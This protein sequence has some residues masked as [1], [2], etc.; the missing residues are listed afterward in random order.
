MPYSTYLGGDSKTARDDV[1]GVTMDPT[2]LI[3]ATGRTQSK[4]FPMTQGGPTIFNSA[5]YL[6]EGK[7]GDEPYLVKINPA[8]PGP[9]SLVY[10]TFLGGG[11]ASGQWGS[12]CTSIAVDARRASYVA[13]ET[14]AQGAPYVP[15]DLKAPQ[16]FPY[17]PNAFLQAPQ[18]SEDALLMNINPSG[19]NLDYSTYLGGT[20]SDRTYG[21]AVDPDGNVVLTGLTFSSN[22]PAQNWPGNVG[23]Q[24]AFVSKFSPLYNPSN[25]ILDHGATHTVTGNITY[26]N[27]YIGQNSTGALI[28]EGFIN[29]VNNN[30]TLGQN[31]GASGAYALSDGS[32]TVGGNEYIGY[33]GS[34]SFTQTG[35]THA[36]TGILILAADAVSSGAYSLNGGSLTV[37]SYEAVG[38]SGTGSFTQSGG[39]HTV[40]ALYLGSTAG[41]SGS[42]TLSD[43]GS[44]SLLA[45]SGNEYIG[46][47]GAGTFT[48]TGGSHTVRGNLTLATTV[49]SSGAYNFQGG[50]LTA[51]TITVN[52]GGFFNQ[53]GGTL[54]GA[55]TLAGGT[56]SAGTNNGLGNQTM[57]INGGTLQATTGTTPILGNPL[58]VGGNF[59]LGGAAGSALELT[60]NLD[61]IGNLLTHNGASND[62]LS[63]NLS[64][65]ATG[66]ITVTAGTLNLTGN[67]AAYAG[68]S[69]VTGGTLNQQGIGN[70]TGDNVVSGGALNM[71]SAAAI[72]YGIVGGANTITGGT[73]DMSAPLAFYLNNTTVTN[74]T[75]NLSAGTYKGGLTVGLGGIFNYTGGAFDPTGGADITTGVGSTTTI[76]SGLN[77]N[78]G[79]GALTNN[80]TTTVNGALTGDL[81]NNAG[82]TVGGTG[83]ITGALVSNGIVNPGNSPGTLTVG[84]Y[85]PGAANTQVVEIASA[86]DY[87]RIVT[88]A[89]VPGAATLNGTLSP[90]LLGGYLPA[91]NQVFPGIVEGTSAGTV[92]GAFNAIDNPRVGSSRTLFWQARYT[93]TTADL[94]AVG[95][96]TPPD[97]ALSRSQQSVGN[98]LHSIAPSTA[99]GDMLTVL[100]AINALT[101]NAGVAAAYTEI[102][103]AKY[104]TLPAMTFP[105]TRMQFQYLQNRLARVR[106]EAALDREALS[107]GRSG[108]GRG[109]NFSYDSNTRMILAASNLT[110]SDAGARYI[111]TEVEQRWGIYL[112]P[113]ANWGS[114]DA[115]ANLAGYRYKNFGF[116]LG[117]EY[118][119]LDNLLVGL[120]TGYSRTI[121]SAGGSGGDLN[122]NII[123]VNAYGAYFHQ[124]FYA[125]AAL[126]YTYSGYDMARNIAFGAINR[127]AQAS[128]SGNQFQLGAETGYDAKIGNAVIGPVVSLQY[129]TQTV[130]GFTESNAG[131]LAL[132]V[133]S[134]TADSLQT[135]LGVRA[136]YNARVGNV[137]VKP[138]LSVTWQHEFS[139]NTR[140]L[141]AS[142]ATGGS[143][144]N[145]QTDK[146]GQDFALI[147]LDI[148]AKITR[149]L[150]ANVGYT[151]EVG[152]NH[153]SNMGAN[154]GLKLKW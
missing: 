53:T 33:S 44:G 49:G 12:W 87:D 26:D 18:G 126:G 63:G 28:Q 2:G 111:T 37:G 141:N 121:G 25:L 148:P 117:A 22:F 154:I 76:A 55:I 100:N 39:T 143:T 23:Y 48:H 38:H 75:L 16:T 144:I 52:P 14:D 83:T 88:T 134:Q 102:S 131:A 74:S 145:F 67:N 130:G 115:T 118:W 77:M 62:T 17:T 58:S 86:T 112:E 10:S 20:R 34:G 61:L 31:A 41:A 153:S 42:Y 78:L 139:D 54:T 32:L 98:A 64:S 149:N 137:A 123:P 96:Y 107:A 60:A 95:N 152:R 122:A 104:A 85:A 108:F 99:G 68:T 80:G 92:T 11:S 127:T 125:N 81:T 24:N 97:L 150:V 56:I 79:G 46:Y 89:A 132:Q 4:G 69:T 72:T 101:T 94:Q 135:G 19:G 105:I 29:M 15:A 103:P 57:T 1:Y 146:I 70:Y 50:S 27:G 124:G 93:A 40:T 73:V 128:T 136:S 119:V 133:D 36:V 138:H 82:G 120:N 84:T 13:G 116:T 90:Q 110:I 106:W 142:L 151:T 59:N 129:A 21:L 71:N 5:P 91:T 45:V 8:L 65:T 114:L 43:S 109:F 147:S 30:L 7:S 3:V 35:G 140:G 113:N 6:E 66:G 47:S 51:G 9:A